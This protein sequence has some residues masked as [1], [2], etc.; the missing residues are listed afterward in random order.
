VTLSQTSTRS[1]PRSPSGTD[2]R[3]RYGR[4]TQGAG[5]PS[6]LATQNADVQNARAQRMARAL[7]AA[8]ERPWPGFIAPA[9]ATLVDTP[10]KGE[11]WVHEIKYDGYRF[12]PRA[13]SQFISPVASRS[14]RR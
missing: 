4:P 7:E 13:G 9:L 8:E 3:D 10:P 11:R 1:K 2:G 12:Q 5:P 14:A 6:P